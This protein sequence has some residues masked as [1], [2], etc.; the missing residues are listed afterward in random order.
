MNG[1][2]PLESHLLRSGALPPLVLYTVITRCLHMTACFIYM[3]ADVFECSL[4]L[5]FFVH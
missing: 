5:N 1:L 3:A 2:S 4:R